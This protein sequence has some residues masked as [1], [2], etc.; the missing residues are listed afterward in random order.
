MQR[1]RT[2]FFVFKPQGEKA[3]NY[4][5]SSLHQPEHAKRK[6]GV[7]MRKRAF[8]RSRDPCILCTL[9]KREYRK[10]SGGSDAETPEWSRGGGAMP[11]YLKPAP[12]AEPR[13]ASAFVNRSVA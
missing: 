6:G 13:D 11:E 1:W 7:K 10:H 9:P 8:C 2:A 5:L 3:V 12:D 4:A